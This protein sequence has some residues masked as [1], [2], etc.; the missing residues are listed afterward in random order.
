MDLVPSVCVSGRNI[1][2]G[3]GGGGGGGQ[4]LPLFLR[5]E[6]FNLKLELF[7]AIYQR[8]EVAFN[9]RAFLYYGTTH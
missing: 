8:M 1:G 6:Q 7:L 9:Y 2:V 3:G 4:W 5:A